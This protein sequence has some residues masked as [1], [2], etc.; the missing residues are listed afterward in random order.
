M[1][2]ENMFNLGEC[3]FFI[4]GEPMGKIET[5]CFELEKEDN[6]ILNLKYLSDINREI[7][8]TLENPKWFSNELGK[9]YYLKEYSKSLR[10]RKK[11]EKLYQAKFKKLMGK[12]LGM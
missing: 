3:T 11:N 6:E 5:V 7:N 12:L 10:I 8:I 9:H 2:P 4:N 1:P